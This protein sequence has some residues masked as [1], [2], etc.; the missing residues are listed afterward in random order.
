VYFRDSQKEAV[1]DLRKA[2]RPELRAISTV[3]D[4]GQAGTLGENGLL[5]TSQV[6]AYV[7]AIARDYQVIDIA[8]SDPT[9][10]VTVKDV[11]HRVTNDETG[12]TFLL[13]SNGLAVVRRLSVE[14]NY[15]VHQMQM[16]GN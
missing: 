12:T 1:L 9:Q 14:N 8:A 7:P 3:T 16:E 6:H 11:K 15:K 10:L 2:Q 13:G 5:G 4:L